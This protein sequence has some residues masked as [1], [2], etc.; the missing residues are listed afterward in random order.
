MT[1]YSKSQR[2]T[3]MFVVEE[4]EHADGDE[5]HEIRTVADMQRQ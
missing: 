4:D 2:L 3:F 5:A 1:C